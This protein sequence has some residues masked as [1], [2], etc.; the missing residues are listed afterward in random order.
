[1][2]IN[3][4]TTEQLIETYSDIINQL[5]E[6]GVIRTKNL[7]GDL[8]EYL[9]IEHFNKLPNKS[10]LKAAPPGTKNQNVQ[11]LK[12]VHAAFTFHPPLKIKNQNQ[13]FGKMN[14]RNF[15]HFMFFTYLNLWA[16]ELWGCERLRWIFWCIQ[17]WSLS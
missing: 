12:T 9:A 1:M 13:E 17:F 11:N 14:K 10:N 8:G 15:K 16:L 4:L 2:D 7:I 6:R 5:K 3:S